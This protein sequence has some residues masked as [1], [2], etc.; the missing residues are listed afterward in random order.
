MKTIYIDA[1]YRCYLDND[2]TRTAV[3]TDA[4]DGKCKAYIEG[5]RFIPSGEVW[6]RSDG[7]QFT[8]EMIF[9]AIDY[10][11]LVRTQT[12][13]EEDL[14]QMSDMQNALEILGVGP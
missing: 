3:E 6:T 14:A 1:D 7:V 5:F 4:F 12:Q 13:Y 9:P 10:D 8:G 2:G 11:S